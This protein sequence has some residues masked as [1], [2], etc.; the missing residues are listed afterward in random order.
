ML[1]GII[2]GIDDQHVTLRPRAPLPLPG[3]ILHAPPKPLVVPRGQVAVV[4]YAP[5][6]SEQLA[7][8]VAGK[9]GALIESG[10]YIDGDIRAIAPDHA[11]IDS[12]LFGPTSLDHSQLVGVALCEVNRAGTCEIR[13][14]D[15]SRLVLK[16]LD[17]IKVEQGRL[18]IDHPILGRVALAQ[19]ELYE[20]TAAP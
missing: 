19:G 4:L 3:E 16:S 14:E 15:G 2:E 20:V 18:V 5:P 9:P 10:D 8:L 7:R 12:V 11:D 17:R 6:T 13:T 1:A